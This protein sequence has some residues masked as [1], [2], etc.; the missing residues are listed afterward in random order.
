[1]AKQFQTKGQKQN[2]FKQSDKSKTTPK[3]AITQ[4]WS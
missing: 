1:M 2:N 4:K 3:K